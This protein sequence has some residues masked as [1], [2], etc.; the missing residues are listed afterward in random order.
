M[1]NA[2][3]VISNG[4]WR[5][6]RYR[7][8]VPASVLA[9]QFDYQNPDETTDGFFSYRGIWYHL[10]QFMRHEGSLGGRVVGSGKGYAWHGVAGDSYFSGVVI[11]VSDDGET[12]RVGTYYSCTVG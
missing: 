8:E 7:Y 12:Y 4:N 2:V 11:A 10:D 6:F 9:D 3:R 5:Q 1:S